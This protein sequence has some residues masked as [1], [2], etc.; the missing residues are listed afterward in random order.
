MS[1]ALRGWGILK[2]LNCSS[3]RNMQCN[4]SCE[5]CE[6]AISTSGNGTKLIFPMKSFHSSYS[7]VTFV[8]SKPPKSYL[9]W[10]VTKKQTILTFKQQELKVFLLW[11]ISL[12]TKTWWWQTFALHRATPRQ[13]PGATPWH[14]KA[15][16]APPCLC[17]GQAK[18]PPPCLAGRRSTRA[19]H[20]TPARGPCCQTTCWM[21]ERYSEEIL[22]NSFKMRLDFE[23]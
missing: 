21:P 7:K 1:A 2:W 5:I 12:R 10:E 9:L 8:T 3:G 15:V 13:S 19:H 6:N 20:S 18:T 23:S 22:R 14:L 4:G 16:V 17:A 11:Q